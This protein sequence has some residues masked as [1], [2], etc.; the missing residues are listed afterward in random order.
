MVLAEVTASG[1]SVIAKPRVS[2]FLLSQCLYS[3]KATPAS[4]LTRSTKWID[5]DTRSRT[6][7]RGRVAAKHGNPGSK[8]GATQ[9]DHML[10][11]VDGDLLSLVMV[12]VH[13]DP[14]N[15]VVAVLIA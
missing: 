8:L 2:S 5:D 6:S 1:E 4:R 12:G 7:N 14:L 11:N 3:A 13:Q 9:R 15:Q 10:A